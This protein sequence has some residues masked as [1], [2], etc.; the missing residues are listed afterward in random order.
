MFSGLRA[1]V[2]KHFLSDTSP[3]SSKSALFSI[4][5]C[6]QDTQ[7]LDISFLSHLSEYT[8]KQQARKHKVQVENIWCEIR[9]GD[10]NHLN[11]VLRKSTS[12]A[13][14]LNSEYR[15]LSS[16]WGSFWTQVTDFEYGRP[17]LFLPTPPTSDKRGTFIHVIVVF[18][19]QLR[20]F[21]PTSKCCV[22]TR[23]WT[24]T[25]THTHSAAS[26]RQWKLRRLRE[27]AGKDWNQYDSQQGNDTL[28]SA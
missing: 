23:G 18:L 19:L 4:L 7:R 24:H 12:A 9:A 13:A 3:R 17:R 8:N 1:C 27:A 22:D 25:D 16:S 26:R 15:K 21:T 14:K 6:V 11:A 5:P 2:Q 28:W 20:A 10:L